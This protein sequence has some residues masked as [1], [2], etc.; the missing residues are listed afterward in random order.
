MV[1]DVCSVY[2]AHYSSPEIHENPRVIDLLNLSNTFIDVV[3]I[4]YYL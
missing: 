4:N 3:R 2:L 1:Y